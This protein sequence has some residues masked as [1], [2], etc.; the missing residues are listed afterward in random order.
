MASEPRVACTS[1][2]AQAVNIDTDSEQFIQN[3]AARNDKT[4]NMNNRVNM[5][6]YDSSEMNQ[7]VH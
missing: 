2:M 7:L 4:P 6:S 1:R 3:K 5:G